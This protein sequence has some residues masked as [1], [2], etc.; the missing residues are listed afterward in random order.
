MNA[1]LIEAHDQQQRARIDVSE[2]QQHAPKISTTPSFN[3]PP[4]KKK[5]DNIPQSSHIE[6]LSRPPTTSL[7]LVLTVLMNLNPG[8]PEHVAE[9]T[10]KPFCYR[11][12]Q[13][14]HFC[15]SF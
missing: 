7:R 9:M 15:F 5:P 13:A 12:I 14:I 6:Q 1:S 10:D 8:R 4:P 3:K 2:V 11:S